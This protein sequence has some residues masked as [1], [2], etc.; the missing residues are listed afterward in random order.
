[1]VLNQ[2]S[3][4][5]THSYF[6]KKNKIALLELLNFIQKLIWKLYNKI[7]LTIIN[8]PFINFWRVSDQ[9]AWKSMKHLSISYKVIK[10]AKR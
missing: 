9:L 1:M 6:R 8:D 5:I 10:I 7:V 4:K 2:I 3:V